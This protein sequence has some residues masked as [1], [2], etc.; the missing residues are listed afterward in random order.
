M[1]RRRHPDRQKD[2]NTHSERYTHSHKE[3]R[4]KDRHS[5]RLRKTRTYRQTDRKSLGRWAEPAERSADYFLSLCWLLP[6]SLMTTSC[7]S[8][9]CFLSLCRS[10]NYGGIGVVIGHE[11][12]HGFDD[13]GQFSLKKVSLH[14]IKRERFC[15]RLCDWTDEWSMITFAHTHAIR[16]QAC[17]H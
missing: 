16:I 1:L 6:V 4:G 17:D 3:D 10:L 2:T 14:F 9:D 5:K 11:I 8:D 7:F 12:T 15:R 13:K